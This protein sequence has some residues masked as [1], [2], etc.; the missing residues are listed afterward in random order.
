MSKSASKSHKSGKNKKL[1][2]SKVFLEIA[3]PIDSTEMLQP[4]LKLC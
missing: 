2:F 4:N 1:I 3:L